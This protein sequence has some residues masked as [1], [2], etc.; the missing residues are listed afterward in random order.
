MKKSPRFHSSLSLSLTLLLFPLLSLRAVPPAAPSNV[1]AIVLPAEVL[2]TW[3]ASAGADHY[4]VYR[5]DLD[6]RWMPI[7]T[8]L[9]VP[10]YRDT[11]FRSLPCYYQIAACNAAGECAATLEFT[12]NPATAAISLIGAKTRPLSDTSMS[13][14][15]TLQGTGGGDALLEVSPSLN[16]LQPVC[17]NPALASR[18]EFAV[19][20]LAPNTTYFYRLT[21]AGA[22]GAGFTYIDQFTTRP[23]TA[24]PPA[25][26]RLTDPLP[27]LVTD[28]DTP[29]DFTL[30]AAN[31]GGRPLTFF[32]GNVPFGTIW[33]TPPNLTYLPSPEHSGLDYFEC[34]FSDGVFPY[35][36]IVF[37]TVN[38]VLDSPIALDRSVTFTED[39]GGRFNVQ[40]TA[41]DSAPTAV[42]CL[43][44]DGP[45]NGTLTKVP[46]ERMSVQYIPNPNF[47]GVDHFTFR[48][49]DGQRIGNAATVRLRVTPA[50]DTPVANP[51]TVT[52]MR[53]TPQTITLDSSDPDGDLLTCV[54]QSGPSHGTLY[55]PTPNLT[56][57]V[58]Y[59]PAAGYTG[60]D[61][62]TW[63][64]TDPSG[65]AASATVTIDVLR[66]NLGPAANETSVS[67]AY[68]V[69]VSVVLTGSDPDGDALTFTVVTLPS[70]GTLSGVA[71]NLVYTPAAGY[72]GADSF[73][74]KA[75]D[76]QADSAPATVTLSVGPASEPPCPAPRL[77]AVG[78][79]HRQINLSW[80]DQC[81]RETGFRIERS[82]QD[83]T[84]H[85]L[86]WEPI[87][88]VA[89]NVTSFADTSLEGRRTFYYRVI[90]ITGSANP[91]CSNV[92]SASMR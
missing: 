31:P 40:A 4:R 30:T 55:G 50:N 34:G 1:R 3:D 32:V 82:K 80:T 58:T 19:A 90:A 73:A 61:S 12:V 62:F 36:A 79:S 23:Y 54:V 84:K 57:Q 76:G 25:E 69:P 91:P 20:N 83:R 46:F 39:V 17:V 56:G 6:R 60:S 14:A 8:Q 7:A 72:S 86:K 2:L 43:I 41:W 53:D 49:F 77:T 74:F 5:A 28:E 68:G 13:V 64:V 10:R 45:T 66:G 70:H 48:C 89:A 38:S 44:V 88:M 47:N 24:P 35:F 92:A 42:D 71:P 33:G 27:A 51:Q 52:V 65:A 16:S 81:G 63:Q 18:H 15:W 59:A 78:V 9:T 67:T 26:V 37:V 85:E 21:S 29:V 75:N 87:G 22:N 11:D